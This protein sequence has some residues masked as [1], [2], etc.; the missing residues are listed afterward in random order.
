MY[1][2][3]GC[4]RRRCCGRYAG[5]GAQAA[6]QE[7]KNKEEEVEEGQI[8]SWISRSKDFKTP[9]IAD[10]VTPNLAGHR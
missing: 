4:P 8:S 3:D 9:N 10:F 5:L 2:E 6:I 7:E 1:G